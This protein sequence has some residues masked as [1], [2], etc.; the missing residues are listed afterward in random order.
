MT[1]SAP[2]SDVGAPWRWAVAAASAA[3]GKKGVDTTVIDVGDVLAVTDLFVITHGSSPRQV[4]AIAEAVEAHL[5]EIGG[6]S[7]VSVEGADIR[8]WILIDYG[9]FVVHVFDAERR[10]FYQLERLWRDCPVLDWRAA[11][12]GQSLPRS[13]TGA[14]TWE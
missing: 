7:P 5:K 11:A 3:E 14:D 10:V 9:S 6:L 1:T 8:Q 2:V 12:A 4:R 13:R